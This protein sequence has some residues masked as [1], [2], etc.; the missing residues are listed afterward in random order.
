MRWRPWLWLLVS[1]IC[2]LGAVYFW[3]LGEQWA[4]EK[5]AA[6]PSPD[7]AKPATNPASHPLGQ[8]HSAPIQL[9]SAVGNLNSWPATAPGKTNQ[10]SSRFKYRLSNTTQTVG[11]LARRDSAVLL[12]NALFD[13]TRPTVLPIP[14]HLR[15]Q[16]DPGS[17]IVQAH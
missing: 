3:R 8:A 10:A 2:F 4:A 9:L 1:L 6:P 14:D 12:E 17:Y 15:S 5:K 16:G 7:T 11:Q 13:T